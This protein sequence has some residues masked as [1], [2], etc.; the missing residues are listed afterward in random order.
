MVFQKHSHSKSTNKSTAKIGKQIGSTSTV[1]T[2]STKFRCWPLSVAFSGQWSLLVTVACQSQPV[3]VVGQHQSS[4]S[5]NVSHRHPSPLVVCH[6]ISHHRLSLSVIIIHHCQL[7]SLVSVTVSH[8]HLSL[9]V[10]VVCHHQ[11]S[12][13]VTIS[14]TAE[15][16]PP[17]PIPL[18]GYPRQRYKVSSSVRPPRLLLSTCI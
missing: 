15:G 12:L 3:V 5:I 1:F 9:M 4:L 18:E 11:L 13:S 2:K 17:P 14:H 16:G 10:V 7:W 6:C 8:H